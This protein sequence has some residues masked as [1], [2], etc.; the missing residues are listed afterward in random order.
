MTEEENQEG[1]FSEVTSPV[2]RS[3][4]KDIYISGADNTPLQLPI[5]GE[6]VDVCFDD[7]PCFDTHQT[8]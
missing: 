5:D 3:N 4:C 6:F 2:I 1:I 8:V 7:S